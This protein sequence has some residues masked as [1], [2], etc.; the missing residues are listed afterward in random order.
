MIYLN[1]STF[2]SQILVWLKKK[3]LYPHA[4]HDLLHFILIWHQIDLSIHKSR[5]VSIFAESLPLCY[6]PCSSQLDPG[7]FVRVTFLFP[8]FPIFFVSRPRIPQHPLS[9]A[10]LRLYRIVILGPFFGRRR[11]Y[12]YTLNPITQAGETIRAHVVLSN[13]TCAY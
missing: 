9:P 12:I 2:I 11:T 3:S 7:S 10:A 8:I 5:S 13:Q 1:F 4:T 6:S